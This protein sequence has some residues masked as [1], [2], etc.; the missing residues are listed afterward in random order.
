MVHKLN[1]IKN[2]GY[3]QEAQTFPDD[4]VTGKES[5]H[6]PWRVCSWQGKFEPSLTVVKPTANIFPDSQIW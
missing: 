1:D 6:L 2:A 3:W 5:L 4:T